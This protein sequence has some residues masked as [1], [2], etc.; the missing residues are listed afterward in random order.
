MVK[1]KKTTCVFIFERDEKITK[2]KK[3][4]EF[5]VDLFLNVNKFEK[6]VKSGKQVPRRA[7]IFMLVFK[8]IENT[9][10]VDFLDNYKKVCIPLVSNSLPIRSHM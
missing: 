5:Q 3:D 6:Y 10:S 2:G 4:T 8:S 1:F 7:L 9:L